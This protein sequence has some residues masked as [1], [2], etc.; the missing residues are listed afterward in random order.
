[1]LRRLERVVHILRPTMVVALRRN[2]SGNPLRHNMRVT[3]VAVQE[4]GISL[5]LGCTS[6]PR[7]PFI[8]SVTP[9]HHALPNLG[10]CI[11]ARNF[12][13]PQVNRGFT[14]LLLLSAFCYY[15]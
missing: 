13:L 5:S 9:L 15:L 8:P 11:R 10:K 12:C 6:A 1:M 4:Q 2:C 14:G 7:T 3:V